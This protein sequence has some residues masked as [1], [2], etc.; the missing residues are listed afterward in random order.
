[1]TRD[2]GGE[3][4]PRGGAVSA[5]ADVPDDL[6]ARYAVFVH[7]DALEVIVNVNAIPAATRTCGG[8]IAVRAPQ[9][10]LMLGEFVHVEGDQ[11]ASVKAGSARVDQTGVG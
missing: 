9:A 3:N 4:A 7:Q 10:L 8:T 6:D 5:R 11:R 2:K 1:V